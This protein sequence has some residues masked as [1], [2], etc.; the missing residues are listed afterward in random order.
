MGLL[1]GILGVRIMTLP[2][3]VCKKKLESAVP[4]DDNQ[5]YAGLEFSSPGSYG[6]TVFD[7]MDG[8]RLAVNICDDCLLREGQE[9]NVLLYKKKTDVH[10][11]NPAKNT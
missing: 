8:S 11:W 9:G 2:C 4:F 5:P 10:I 6:G 7:P 1:V 3:I